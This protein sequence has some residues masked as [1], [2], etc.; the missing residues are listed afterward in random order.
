MNPEKLVSE[1]GGRITFHGGIDIQK[2]LPFGTPIEVKEQVDFISGVYGENG[3]FIMSGSHHIQAD[4]P[5]ENIL[6]MYNV[7]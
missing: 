5:I 4:T 3:G 2:L 6:A 7:Y 1:F